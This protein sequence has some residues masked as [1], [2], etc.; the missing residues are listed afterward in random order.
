M[1]LRQRD[2]QRWAIKNPGQLGIA[3]PG[4]AAF[5]DYMLVLPS[6]H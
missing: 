3:D 1:A 6:R 2:F 5:A 4:F